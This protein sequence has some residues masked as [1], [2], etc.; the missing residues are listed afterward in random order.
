MNPPDISTCDRLEIVRIANGLLLR[1]GSEDGYCA[2]SYKS[3]FAFP[4]EAALAEALPKLLTRAP[5]QPA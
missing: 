4:S 1:P 5:Q 3:T 2:P